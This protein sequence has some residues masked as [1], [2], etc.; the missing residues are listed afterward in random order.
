MEVLRC[1]YHDAVYAS[2]ASSEGSVTEILLFVNTIQEASKPSDPSAEV[3]ETTTH[4]QNHIATLTDTFL[5]DFPSIECKYS[6]TIPSEMWSRGW[7]AWT[8]LMESNTISE[9]SEI[10]GGEEPPQGVSKDEWN[11]IWRWRCF[12]YST[13]ASGDADDKT[14]TKTIDK[15]VK[16]WMMALKMREAQLVLVVLM[17]CI[18]L[19]RVYSTIGTLP[20]LKLFPKEED[21]NEEEEEDE[22]SRYSKRKRTSKHGR[23]KKKAKTDGGDGFDV[24]IP[25]T[26]AERVGEYVA[27]V[28]Q[29]FDRIMIWDSLF[30]K[31]LENDED[32]AVGKQFRMFMVDCLAKCFLQDVQNIVES[33][34]IKAGLAVPIAQKAKP[35]TGKGVASKK[36]KPDSPTHLSN[37]DLSTKVVIKPPHQQQA[38]SIL[39]RMSRASSRLQQTSVPSM[40][41]ISSSQE[42]LLSSS[43]I[44]STSSANGI[45]KRSGSSISDT[46]SMLNTDGFSASSVALSTRSRSNRSSLTSLSNRVVSLAPKNQ[47]TASDKAKQVLLKKMEQQKQQENESI[48]SGVAKHS[49]SSNGCEGS[50]KSVTRISKD[51]KAAI[52]KARE[53]KLMKAAELMAKRMNGGSSNSSGIVLPAMSTGGVSGM[54][55]ASV[56][57]RRNGSFGAVVNEKE[58]LKNDLK[59]TERLRGPDLVLRRQSSSLVNS[60]TANVAATTT[61]NSKP[62]LP[63]ST[64]KKQVASYRDPQ[65]TPTSQRRS[66]ISRM[67]LPFLNSGKKHSQD[68]QNV[69]WN[70]IENSCMMALQ[71][72]QMPV[73]DSPIKDFVHERPAVKLKVRSAKKR[74]AARM[75]DIDSLFQ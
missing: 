29:L 58:R 74:M 56:A 5:G 27:A 48:Q 53:E 26:P 34:F 68:F 45:P 1:T 4:L 17:E 3:N 15:S 25:V 33:L 73:S 41:T 20:Q 28:V 23:T 47:M 62:P 31:A 61:E 67:T 8:P 64:P 18:R 43:Q 38:S 21:R 60:N 50:T 35:L 46:S 42:S 63:P 51:E 24:E 37:S 69:N 44:S 55:A 19:H 32:A 11:R 49:L 40:A 57:L 39:R 9:T 52:L 30:F 36:R 70:E 22:R 13:I 72:N 71:E 14:R 6:T 75:L 16:E 59:L 12:V 65:S 10:L 66:R 54:T 2:S 7:W